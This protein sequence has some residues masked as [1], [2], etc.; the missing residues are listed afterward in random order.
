MENTLEA[1]K[2]AILHPTGTLAAWNESGKNT[3]Y[4]EGCRKNIST[5]KNQKNSKQF[6]PLYSSIVTQTKVGE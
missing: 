5:L 2:E 4:Y 6:L 1:Q 3:F